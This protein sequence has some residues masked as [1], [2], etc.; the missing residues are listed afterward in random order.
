M[1]EANQNTQNTTSMP[2]S[3][4]IMLTV[5]VLGIVM[6]GAKFIFA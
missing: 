2:V 4:L 6:L 1:S 3:L 5:L